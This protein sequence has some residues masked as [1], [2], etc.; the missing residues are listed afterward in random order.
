MVVF[1]TYRIKLW[2]LRMKY[3]VLRKYVTLE[4]C[5][6]RLKYLLS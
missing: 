6:L 5:V 4:N 1:K 3:V 2:H